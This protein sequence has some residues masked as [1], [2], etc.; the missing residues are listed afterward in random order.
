MAIMDLTRLHVL[1]VAEARHAMISTWFN[2]RIDDISAL[3]SLPIVTSEVESL[4]A[5]RNSLPAGVLEGILRSQAH[6]ETYESL[7]VLDAD[8]NILAES[9]PGLHANGDI[10][11]PAFRERIRN[12]KEVYFGEAHIH[13]DH[14]VGVHLGSTITNNS[15]ETVGYLVGNLNITTSIT[16]LLQERSGLW[17]T[18][19]AYIVDSDSRVLTEP[20]GNVTGTAFQA[21]GGASERKPRAGEGIRSVHVYEDFLAHEVI[22]VALPF[23]AYGWAVVVEIDTDESLEW[24]RTLLFRAVLLL[25]AVLAAVISVSIW[26]S[27]LLGKPLT[28]LAAVTHRISEGYTHERLGPMNLEEA[29]E[30]RCAFN[31]M[32]DELR[33]KE[34]E[35]VRSAT[36]A[37]VGELTSRVVHEMRN[38]LSSVKMN[39]QALQRSVEQNPE[40]QELADIAAGQLCRLECMLNELLQYGRPLELSWESVDVESLFNA[41]VADTREYSLERQIDIDIEIK[42]GVGQIWVDAEQFKRVMVNLVKNAVE[43]SPIGGRVEIRAQSADSPNENVLIEVTDTGSGIRGEHHDMLFKPFFTTKSE[44]IG[45]GLANVKKIVSLHSG[46][47]SARNGRSAGAVFSVTIPRHAPFKDEM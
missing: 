9:V 27:R 18:G 5:R 8:W 46:L 28:Q 20:F 39:F 29:E 11:T 21:H 19:K 44:G 34:E 35:I 22:G 32:L 16:S 36:L 23:Q 30:V 14:D 13:E 41:V 7:T 33:D 10:A 31:R 24:V 40:N 38:P 47:I 43:A 17:Q 3:V 12:T 26:L 37:T 25:I 6:G 42:P 1:S 4:N 15:G 2:E 45:L